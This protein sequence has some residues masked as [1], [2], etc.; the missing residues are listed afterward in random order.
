MFFAEIMIWVSILISYLNTRICFS[1]F[2]KTIWKGYFYDGSV[3][4]FWTLVVVHHDVLQWGKKRGMSN[5]QGSLPSGIA[6][7]RTLPAQGISVHFQP[8]WLSSSLWSN[9]RGCSLWG[10]WASSVPSLPPED[11]INMSEGRV[12]PILGA[13]GL[14]FR[15]TSPAHSVI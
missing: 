15:K 9:W 4:L 14:P 5:A 7:G 13:P 10:C 2:P 1:T 6:K 3:Y 8:G 12:L 11:G